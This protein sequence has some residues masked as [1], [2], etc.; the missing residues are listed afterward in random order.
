VKLVQDEKV[1]EVI[2]F[3]T[4]TT[5]LHESDSGTDVVVVHDGLPPGVLNGHADGPRK[6]RRVARTSTA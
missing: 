2:E 6:A 3:E 1:V 5:T 4:I